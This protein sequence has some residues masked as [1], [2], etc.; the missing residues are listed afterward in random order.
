MQDTQHFDAQFVLDVLLK[1]GWLD[2]GSTDPGL[3]AVAHPM[4]NETIMVP[5]DPAM[6]MY[7]RYVS[8]IWAALKRYHQVG[9]AAYWALEQLNKQPIGVPAFGFRAEGGRIVPDQREQAALKRMKELRR[10]GVALR[11]IGSILDREGH[12]PRR[13]QKW[14]GQTINNILR[15]Q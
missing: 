5:L 6:P 4:G 11:T 7:D 13:A 3:A 15:R 14:T 10:E 1:S 8:A 9:T 12:R 2:V